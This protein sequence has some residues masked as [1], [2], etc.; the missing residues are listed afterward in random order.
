MRPF[1]QHNSASPARCS[2]RPSTRR[3]CFLLLRET[4]RG[5]Q[6]ACLGVWTAR[7]TRQSRL[8]RRMDSQEDKSLA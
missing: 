3:C 1:P 7:K 4:R 8:L 2:L 6:V 5:R